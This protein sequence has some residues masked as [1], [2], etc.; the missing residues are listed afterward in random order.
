MHT[1]LLIALTATLTLGFVACATSD[2]ADGAAAAFGAAEFSYNAS[3][4]R[5]MNAA[6]ETGYNAVDFERIAATV[7]A[8]CVDLSAR[9]LSR[10]A[11]ARDV[12]W[13]RVSFRGANLYATKFP[14][15]NGPRR[16]DFSGADIRDACEEH[17]GEIIGVVD[18][19]T[20]LGSNCVQTDGQARC[21]PF[22]SDDPN[23][24]LPM[25]GCLKK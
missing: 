24:T 11:A 9:V 3:L 13:R 4:G 10:D 15:F 1:P 19:H 12:D 25:G 18:K 17:N 23:V 16:S 7:D 22:K 20:K 2:T 6:G 5:C 14:P 8:E 21:A